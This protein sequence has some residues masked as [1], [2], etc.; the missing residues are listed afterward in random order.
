MIVQVRQYLRPN[1]RI[2]NVTTDLSDDLASHYS[3]MIALGWN[4]GAEVL[5]TGNISLTIED[6]DKGEDITGRIV[7]NDPSVQSAMEDMLREQFPR[8]R[9]TEKCQNR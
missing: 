1:G 8:E 5:T 4:F 3:E 9:K 2:E 6:L 7:S